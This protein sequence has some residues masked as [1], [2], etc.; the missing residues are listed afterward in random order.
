MKLRHIL[1]AL[2]IATCGA[3]A[4]AQQLQSA[5]FLDGY[6]L[7]HE[8]NPAKDYERNGYVAIPVISGFQASML[9]NLNT[10][11]ILR[12]LPGGNI[13][14]YLN[15]AIGVDDALG[16]FSKNNKFVEDLHLNLVSVGFHAWG[17]FNT[18]G[19]SLR[20]R[21]GV[22]VPYEF[23]ELTK[24][25]QN[26]NYNVSSFG[27]TAHAYAELALGH[28]REVIDGLRV[29]AKVKV[30]LGV[31]RFNAQMDNLSLNLAGTDKWT[32]NANATI[33]ANINGLEWGKKIH[34]YSDGSKQEIIDF[35]N[36]DF[37]FKGLAGTGFALDL[38]AEADLGKFCEP[39]EGLTVSAAVTDLGTISW[40]KGVRAVTN[41][42][43]F[44]FD[45][46]NDIKIGDNDGV[47]FDD[48]TDDLGDRL[49]KLYNLKDG[50]KL[51]SN[52]CGLGTTYNVAA[53]YKMPFYKQLSVGLL[54]TQRLQS[55]YGWN[56]ERLAVTVKPV[57]WFEASTNVAMGTFG[58]SW[59]WVLNFHP[60]GVNV[61]LGMDHAPLG[62][63]LTKEF[64]PL[65]SKAD[66]TFGIAF[67]FGKLMSKKGTEAK[68]QKR[69]KVESQ[70]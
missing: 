59:G 67:P 44:V 1:P 40:K 48:Q 65:K 5:Y 15:P 4:S 36:T 53:E 37:A 3:S 56:E 16:R 32:A 69:Q 10:N 41:G 62:K 43:P 24:N 64:I 26:K 60:K 7:G 46:F 14:T 23:F 66:F 27:A 2:A 42:Q 13:T 68:S 12:K 58:T 54:H 8:M 19:L 63:C 20:E 45:G 17:G 61:F 57:S 38:G 11:D 51:G 33:D 47:D 55:Q 18:V 6:T 49:E 39:L 70:E 25:L 21:A 29:G 30:L 22:N 35:D 34:E 50:G 9:G 31:G 28:S 52:G